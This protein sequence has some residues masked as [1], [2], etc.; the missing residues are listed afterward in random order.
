MTSYN[1]KVGR[2]CAAMM[3][4]VLT[5][6]AVHGQGP[7]QGDLKPMVDGKIELEFRLADATG[8]RRL[9]ATVAKQQVI[10]TQKDLSV[11]LIAG[12]GDSDAGVREE[13]CNLVAA[14]AGGIRF[15]P[16]PARREDWKQD[17]PT[18]L[19]VEAQLLQLIAS[20]P[21]EKVR[22]AAILAQDNVEYRGDEKSEKDIKISRALAETLAAR[23]T[24]EPA[25][26]VRAEIVKSMAL[27]SSDSP[28]HGRTIQL[29]LADPAPGVI[30]LALAGIGRMK[31][32]ESLPQVVELLGHPSAKVRLASVQALGEFGAVAKPYVGRL[33]AAGVA[34]T[35]N[36]VRASIQG[37][38]ARI[39]AAK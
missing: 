38:V 14:K 3:L 31:L 21:S 19:S 39:Q 15:A 7:A 26:S 4:C 32:A 30:Q 1:V 17:R 5:V 18:L 29:A 6:T 25:E 35:D 33:T 16:T 10:L 11:I 9:L 13:T 34:E 24:K 2:G 12:L 28:T 23:Y 36:N 27:A 20:D 22:L 37:L 8:K